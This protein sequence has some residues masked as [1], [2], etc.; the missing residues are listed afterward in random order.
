MYYELPMHCIRLRSPTLQL[1]STQAEIPDSYF[2]H[3]SHYPGTASVQLK[4]RRDIILEIRRKRLALRINRSHNKKQ[5]Q[6]D[7]NPY[8]FAFPLI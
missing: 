2:D 4:N 8:L 3:L 7:K 5:T 1:S 6:K